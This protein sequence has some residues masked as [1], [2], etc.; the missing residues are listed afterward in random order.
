MLV[1]THSSLLFCAAATAA[2]A[3]ASTLGDTQVA[4][5]PLCRG[6]GVSESHSCTN[7]QHQR[8]LSRSFVTDRPFSS[9]DSSWVSSCAT[10]VSDHYRCPAVQVARNTARPCSSFLRCQHDEIVCNHDRDGMTSQRVDCSMTLRLV[11]CHLFGVFLRRENRSSGGC[12]G[13]ARRA[14]SGCLRRPPPA[15]PVQQPSCE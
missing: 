10:I 2:A 3:A 5:F 9:P 7:R 11:S 12:A 4:L 6:Y 1:G 8:E 14:D 13:S 15:S